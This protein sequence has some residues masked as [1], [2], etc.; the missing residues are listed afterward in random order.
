MRWDIWKKLEVFENAS[1]HFFS[2]SRLFSDRIWDEQIGT[3]L[4]QVKKKQI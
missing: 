1:K 4:A 2:L 3:A